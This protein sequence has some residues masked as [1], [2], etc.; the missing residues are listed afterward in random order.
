MAA[1]H[2]DRN[3]STIA[4]QARAAAVVLAQLEHAKVGALLAGDSARRAL[5]CDS[6]RSVGMEPLEVRRTLRVQADGALVADELRPWLKAPRSADAPLRVVVNEG[7]G[8]YLARP[9]QMGAEVVVEDL[10]DL[11][12]REVGALA[13]VGARTDEALAKFFEAACIEGRNTQVCP[14]ADA[15]ASNEAERVLGIL[16]PQLA[17]ITQARCDRALVTAQYLAHHPR[18]ADVRYP[19]L[20]DDPA[21]SEARRSLEHGFG[22]LVSFRLPCDSRGFDHGLWEEPMGFLASRVEQRADGLCVLHAGLEEALD[23]VGALEK[24]IACGDMA[25]PRA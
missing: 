21:N 6:D 25:D 16:L 24:G 14:A 12:G 20:Q 23:V 9:C 17:M 10:R 5:F 7:A 18:V 15:A 22:W 13:F 19:G 2:P 8:P 3:F 4:N 1:L 11:F